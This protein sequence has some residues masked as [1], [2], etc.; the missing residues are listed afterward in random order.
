MKAVKMSPCLTSYPTLGCSFHCHQ[1]FV[2]AHILLRSRMSLSCLVHHPVSNELP[3]NVNV[4]GRP[5]KAFHH[6]QLGRDTVGQQE[7]MG[8]LAAL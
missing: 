5:C 3:A 1:M 2:A 4:A 7:M 6:R 8:P